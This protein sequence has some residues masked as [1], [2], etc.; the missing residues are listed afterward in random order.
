MV[1][2]SAKQKEKLSLVEIALQQEYSIIKRVSISN[3]DFSTLCVSGQ[4][5]ALDTIS[6]DHCD[7]WSA[8]TARLMTYNEFLKNTSTIVAKSLQVIHA[9]WFRN[10]FVK[11]PNNRDVCSFYLVTYLYND[12]N[13]LFY[14]IFFVVKIPLKITRLLKYGWPTSKKR[15]FYGI[16]FVRQP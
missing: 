7:P 12:L 15:I 2:W 3:G 9:K 11:G 5:V 10:F 16:A 6:I 1:F 8:I 4:A 14:C 13:N